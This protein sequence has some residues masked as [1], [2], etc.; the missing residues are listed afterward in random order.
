MIQPEDFFTRRITRSM[1][2]GLA[3]AASALALQVA[4]HNRWTGKPGRSF[5]KMHES[6]K[7]LAALGE[8]VSKRILR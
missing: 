2:L 1:L 3:L 4:T 7:K 6:A 8:I 5:L